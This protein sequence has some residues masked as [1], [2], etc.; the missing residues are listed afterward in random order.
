M[1]FEKVTVPSDYSPG[2]P[3]VTQRGDA[4]TV[5]R[6][7]PADAR[8]GYWTASDGWKLR[9]FDWPAP[10]RRGRILFQTGRGDSVEK[11]LETFAHLHA[12]GWSVTAFDWRGQGGSGRL[13]TDGTGHIDRLDNL[14]EDLAEALGRALLL[15]E[16]GQLVLDQGMVDHRD[17]CADLRA[18]TVRIRHRLHSPE[19]R[20]TVPRTALERPHALLNSRPYGPPGHENPIKKRGQDAVGAR[21]GR[22]SDANRVVRVVD[23]TYPKQYAHEQVRP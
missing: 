3:H 23:E 2:N 6:A 13:T 7:I 22:R 15:A 12:Q 10:A 20:P 1:A 16:Q 21:P 8:I 9:R 18:G 5:R 11:Y 14:V 4:A 19:D 17:R